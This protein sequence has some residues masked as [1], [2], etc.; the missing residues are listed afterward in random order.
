MEST[1]KIKKTIKCIKYFLVHNIS[2]PMSSLDC[3]TVRIFAYSS[4]DNRKTFYYPWF[5]YARAVNKQKVRNEAENRA[6]DYGRMSLLASFARVRHTPRFTDFFTEFEKKKTPLF[7]SLWVAMRSEGSRRAINQQ[8][9]GLDN[10]TDVS[11]T[12]A[13]TWAFAS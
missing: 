6:R 11:S 4:M 2:L 13:K 5:K 10:V 1:L 3:K 9:S 7:C 12:V 8:R